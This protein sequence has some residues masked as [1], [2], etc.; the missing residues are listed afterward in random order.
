LDNSSGTGYPQ[1]LIFAF[2]GAFMTEQKTDSQKLFNYFFIIVS[3]AVFAITA[4]RCSTVPFAHDEAG[5]FFLFI[6]SGAFLPYHAHINTNN[7]VLNSCLSWV[8][9]KLF[10]DAPFF[11]R[12]PN[13]LALLVLI[14]ATYRISKQLTHVYSKLLLVAG[15][16]LSFHWLSFY[17]MCRGYGLSMA[18]LV[19]SV[20]YLIEYFKS[21]EL[22]KIILFYLFIQLAISANLVL[23]IVAAV[24]TFSVMVFQLLNNKLLKAGNI[25]TLLIHGALI[26]FWVKFSFFLQAHNQFGYSQPTG[27]WHTTFVPLME[28]LTGTTSRWMP[29]FIS[30]SFL[31]LVIG[32]IAGNFRKVKA[33]IQQ[34]FAPSLFY[35]ILLVMLAVVFYGMKKF[36]NV[37]YPEDR[38]ALFFYVFFIVAA[39]FTLDMFS[40]IAAK[41]LSGFIV[42]GALVHFACNVN[43]SKHAFGFYNT[44]PERFYTRLLEEQK[45]NP[46]KITISGQIWGEFIYDF[47]NYRYKG[48][49]NLATVSSQEMGMNCDYAISWKSHENLYKPYYNE[50][51]ADNDW[52]ITLLKRK[53]KIK[54]NLL[55]S[56]D[57]FKPLQG[58]DEYYN[59][60]HIEDTAFKNRNPLLME[61]NIGPIQSEMPI[62]SWLVFEI[63]STEG[64]TAC[65]QRIPLNWL[66]YDWTN[67]NN[68]TLDLVSGQLPRKI[69]R[70]VCYLWNLE[71]KEIKIKVNSVKIYQLEG[72][73]VNV[74]SPMHGRFQPN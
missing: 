16:L 37:N 5:T 66:R 30:F 23:I 28:L 20:A 41:A 51:D 69:S 65:Y 4:I 14:V 32:V 3:V 26:L 57:S 27:Y 29:I 55:M 15:F 19:L 74:V 59:L 38:M 43:L 47:W 46:E 56:V 11:L 2:I 36:L 40:G 70:M 42:I 6:Q 34:V 17:S 18:F 9:F 1:N 31:I 12:L 54:R 24:L 39:A 13:L 58:K 7:H 62:L 35:T 45:G 53:E 72:N 52:G 49:L 64:H 61:V 50:I 60:Y 71:Q 25:I 21:K 10:S 48:A 33:N 63:D 22:K 67:A 73:G 8:C 44:I 68:E